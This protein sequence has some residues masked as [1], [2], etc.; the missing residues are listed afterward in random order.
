MT[1]KINLSIQVSMNENTTILLS[2]LFIK[3]DFANFYFT[4][5]ALRY[6]STTI[7]VKYEEAEIHRSAI[8]QDFRENVRKQDYISPGAP[9]PN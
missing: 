2:T 5:A 8:M 4:K 6:G 1:W 3:N 9:A 7:F